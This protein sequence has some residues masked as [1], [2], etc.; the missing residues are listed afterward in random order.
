MRSQNT[1]PNSSKS[2]FIGYFDIKTFFVLSSIHFLVKKR[3]RDLF[4]VRTRRRVQFSQNFWKTSFF[5][6]DDFC[7]QKNLFQLIGAST[8]S[9]VNLD[10]TPPMSF[11]WYLGRCFGRKK[12]FT[13]V[14]CYKIQSLVAW[15]ATSLHNKVLVF[16][17]HNF[18]FQKCVSL[19]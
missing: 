6:G 8:V 11:H 3:V 18:V 5:P 9:I 2:F 14:R 16:L 19:W 17:C 13:I 15:I 4:K 1:R 10:V 12:C 7:P